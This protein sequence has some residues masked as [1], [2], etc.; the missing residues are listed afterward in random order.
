MRTLLALALVAAM[1]SPLAAASLPKPIPGYVQKFHYVQTGTLV[2]RGAFG[3]REEFH[4]ESQHLIIYRD[5]LGVARAV[6]VYSGADGEYK[7]EAIFTVNIHAV[8]YEFFRANGIDVEQACC[9]SVPVKRGQDKDYRC[10]KIY[11]AYDTTKAFPHNMEDAVYQT[12][13]VWMK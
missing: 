5:Y 11:E 2:T 4:S 10:P 12:G 9:F 6:G 1:T 7:P 3:R 13:G 8:V